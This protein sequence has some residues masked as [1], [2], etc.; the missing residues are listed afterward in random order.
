MKK[1][2]KNVWNTIAFTFITFIAMLLLSIGFP[3]LV[4]M[5]INDNN[6]WD[7]RYFNFIENLG[8]ALGKL[9]LVEYSFSR[10]I[11]IWVF[12]KYYLRSY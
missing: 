8:E 4:H 7:Y 2:L 12:Y 6:T 1:L 9:L 3:L 5:V 10:P 11:E